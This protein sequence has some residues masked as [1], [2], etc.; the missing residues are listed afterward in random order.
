[1]NI[2]EKALS[3]ATDL[4]HRLKEILGENLN[5]FALYGSAVRGDMVPDLSDVNVLIILNHSSPEAHRTIAGILNEFP[6]ISP[7]ILSRWELPHSRRV[8]AVKFSSI[9]RHYKVLLGDD[10]LADFGPSQAL[11]SFL[12]E[13]SIR[14]LRLRLK[15]DYIRFASNPARYRQVLSNQ[16]ASLFVSLSE[17]L[18][19]A[20]IEVPSSRQKRPEVIGKVFRTEASVLTDLLALRGTQ[21]QLSENEA[22]EYHARL[23]S[24][25]SSALEW[26]KERWPQA[27]EIQ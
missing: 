24:L 9:G 15:R 11:L 7:F 12:L 4:C 6:M 13:Q 1:M 8:F 23:F 18:R 20:G 25:L 3:M 5:S 26:I 10:P 16:T 14:N 2:N 17:V 22:F 21:K 19:S 27:T